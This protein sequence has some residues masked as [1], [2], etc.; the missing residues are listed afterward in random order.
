MALLDS[1]EW[2][3]QKEGIWHKWDALRIWLQ[4]NC[5]Q[6]LSSSDRICV[7]KEC[8]IY[9]SDSFWHFFDVG[10]SQPL[11]GP[12]IDV[13]WPW[14]KAF[15]MVKQNQH[16]RHPSSA[17]GTVF[18]STC[19]CKPCLLMKISDYDVL[20]RVSCFLYKKKDKMGLLPLL[21]SNALASPAFFQICVYII[22]PC[23][24]ICSL[25]FSYKEPKPQKEI[26]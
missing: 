11:Q 20:E 3:S 17:S 6:Y 12:Y 10:L 13:Q 7:L 9:I 19:H 18:W 16:H 14:H 24:F 1:F 5:K 22:S 26:Y 23:Y 25:C 15:D 2:S 21:T 4:Y 8:L